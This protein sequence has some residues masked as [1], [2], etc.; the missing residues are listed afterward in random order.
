MLKILSKLWLKFSGWSIG[1][2]PPDLKK[3]VMITA[4]HTSNWDF[5]FMISFASVFDMK[6]SW[7]GKHTLFNWPFGWF[8]TA[9]G[10]V[11][12]NRTASTNV[13]SQM[14]E[15]FHNSERL[16]LAIPAEGTRSYHDHWKSGFYH[17]AKA[18]DVPI[19]PSILD[20]GRK[21][22]H[23]G[24]PIFPT[25]AKQVMA[26]LSKQYESVTGKFPEKFSRISL[27]EESEEQEN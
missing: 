25:S 8:F 24:S 16:I 20:Y 27:K 9:L 7:M 21:H 22:G 13:V 5:V 2:G 19:V 3:F 23:V 26:D 12:I 1:Q 6:M 4:P 15:L 17:I 10:G 11:P 18:A 14:A